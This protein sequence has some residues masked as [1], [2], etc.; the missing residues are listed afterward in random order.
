MAISKDERQVV[1]S[2]LIAC[3][4]PVVWILYEVS[5][6]DPFILGA[7]M[8]VSL[9]VGPI[10]AVML[11]LGLRKAKSKNVFLWSLV[12]VNAAAPITIAVLLGYGW[13]RA[14]SGLGPI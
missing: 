9:F 7:C 5:N 3:I 14:Q 12:V 2:G 10:A 6:R 1:V 13:Q 8:L 11:G 4:L